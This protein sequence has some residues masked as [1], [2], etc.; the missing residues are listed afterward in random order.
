MVK[1]HSVEWMKQNLSNGFKAKKWLHIG[2]WYTE[3]NDTDCLT[4]FGS[5]F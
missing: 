1:V 3:V 2:Y 5:T 4:Q